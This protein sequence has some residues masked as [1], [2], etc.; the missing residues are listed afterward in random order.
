[1]QLVPVASRA[2]EKKFI[3]LPVFLYR[4]YR[5]WIR[6]LDSDIR[7]VFD[8][9]LNRLLDMEHVRG[10]CLKTRAR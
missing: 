5:T 10:G 9:A 1:M 3:D 2:E 4:N 7:A 8:P 6:P